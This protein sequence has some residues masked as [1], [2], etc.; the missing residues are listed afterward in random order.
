MKHQ[1]AGKGLVLMA[2]LVISVIG[3]IQVFHDSA[4]S[5]PDPCTWEFCEC[6]DPGGEI[7]EPPGGGCLSLHPDRQC[8]YNPSICLPKTCGWFCYVCIES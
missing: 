5:C 7:P 6:Y 1:L 3:L 8:D 4:Y 2:A